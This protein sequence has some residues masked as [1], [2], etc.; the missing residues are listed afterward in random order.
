MQKLT[1]ILMVT[2]MINLLTNNYKKRKLG[3]FFYFLFVLAMCISI[4]IFSKESAKGALDGIKFCVLVLVPSLFPFVALSCFVVRSGVCS[5]AE[6]YLGKITNYC[7]GLSGA[8][9]VIFFLSMIGGYPVGAKGISSL[10]KNGII[11]DTEAAKMAYYSVGA[12]PGFLVTFVGVSLLGNEEAGFILLAAQIITMFLL[13]V[14]SKFIFKKYDSNNSSAHSKKRELKIEKQG[15]ICAIVDSTADAVTAIIAMCGMVVVFSAFTEIIESFLRNA[16]VS[17]Q[18]GVIVL[19][20]VTTAC[21]ILAKNAPLEA[22][23]FAVGFGGLSVHFQVFAFLNNI[24]VNKVV[25]MFYRVVQGLLTALVTHFLLIA[26]PITIQVFSSTTSTTIN[27][28]ATVAGS[29]GL[30]ATALCFL[31]SLKIGKVKRN[32]EITNND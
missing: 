13:A 32:A 29:I 20:E 21:N 11:S 24:P 8:C 2:K 19:M 10:Y 14:I 16:D 25:F 6:P 12:G 7:F 5:A 3:I 27:T 31:F 1:Y 28:N 17:V 4:L 30:L 26:F 15:F 23:A 22:V 18:N 9:G